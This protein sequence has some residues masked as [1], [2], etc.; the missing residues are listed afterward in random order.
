MLMLF[1]ARYPVVFATTPTVS[2]PT[3]VMMIFFMDSSF[4]SWKA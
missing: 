4:F 3:T 1:F 2:W